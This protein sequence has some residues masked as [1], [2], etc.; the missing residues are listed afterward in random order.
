MQD[1]RASEVMDT[2]ST[3]GEDEAQG[4]VN[5]L[6]LLDL[7]VEVLGMVTERLSPPSVDSLTYTSRGL[8]ETVPDL[9]R[10]LHVPMGKTLLWSALQRFPKVQSVDGYVQ[11]TDTREALT[12]ASGRL[13]GN[14]RLTIDRRPRNEDVREES[15]FRGPRTQD[16]VDFLM[17][18]AEKYPDSVCSV[19]VIVGTLVTGG[20]SMYL[21]E[22]APGYLYL[23]IGVPGDGPLRLGFER[24]R[25]VTLGLDSLSSNHEYTNAFIKSLSQR[26]PIQTLISR[27]GLYGVNPD[28][29]PHLR[30]VMMQH[31]PMSMIYGYRNSHASLL[32]FSQPARTITTIRD[33]A[34]YHRVPETLPGFPDRGA[35][36]ILQNF[37]LI[38]PNVRYGD[39]TMHLTLGRWVPGHTPVIKNTISAL[40]TLKHQTSL[41]IS[42]LIWVETHRPLNQAVRV[43]K[44]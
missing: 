29:L 44:I 7:P 38:Y 16:F 25:I 2:V 20:F 19:N 23:T 8:R 1:P 12:E 26:F 39:L 3:E 31:P 6:G 22:Y 35:E 42:L 36:Y 43:Y 41:T 18:R 33:L 34:L 37:S 11:I 15:I 21:Y 5:S 17:E 14:I 30:T 9:T 10:R 28:L 32:L 13:R 24:A 40:T 4:P 27:E